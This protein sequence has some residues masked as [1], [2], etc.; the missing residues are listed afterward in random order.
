MCV[1]IFVNNYSHKLYRKILEL[2]EELKVVGNNLKSLEVS[3][4]KAR[5]TEIE[6]KSTIKNL[7]AKLKQAEARAEF[8]ERTVQ[9]LLKEVDRIEGTSLIQ[10][11][12]KFIAANWKGIGFLNNIFSNFYRRAEE[13][14]R[15]VQV[16]Y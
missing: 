12:S 5:Q 16:N 1:C 6:F 10:M 7:T 11:F 13:R 4:E 2:E 9:K 3:E 14:T 15:K 8:A